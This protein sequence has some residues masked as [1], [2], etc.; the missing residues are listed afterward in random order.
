MA[1]SVVLI[2]GEPHNVRLSGS[3][4]TQV[5]GKASA[6]MQGFENKDDGFQKVGIQPRT[7]NQSVPDKAEVAAA[8]SRKVI[9]STVSSKGKIKSGNKVLFKAGS[10][11]LP[12]PGKKEL[13][14][15]A[16]DIVTKIAKSV[17]IETSYIANDKESESL[18]KDRLAACKAYLEKNGVRSNVILT[19]T[20]R[21]QNQSN[22]VSIILR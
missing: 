1:Q 4:I 15:K 2:N 10:S 14:K 9:T 12:L 17:L 19:N 7:P 16:A 21:E 13:R 20:R 11:E 3:E 18:A 22:D 5:T 6:H 8:S